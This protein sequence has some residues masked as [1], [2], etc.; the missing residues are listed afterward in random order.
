MLL[1]VLAILMLMIFA[2]GAA[3]AAAPRRIVSIN[4]C[5]DQYLLALADRDQIVGLSQ[6]AHNPAMSFASSTDAT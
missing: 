1:R 5:A 6:W 2:G 3:Q 4:L